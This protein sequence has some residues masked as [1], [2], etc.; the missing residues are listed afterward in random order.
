MVKTS[1]A[2]LALEQ[3]WPLRQQKRASGR[4]SAERSFEMLDAISTDRLSLEQGWPIRQQNRA[5]AAGRGRADIATTAMQI[6]K[7]MALVF[8][9]IEWLMHSV[10]TENRIRDS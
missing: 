4:G 5:S 3:G 1:S 10:T 7:L 2:R 9:L 6:A 8:I